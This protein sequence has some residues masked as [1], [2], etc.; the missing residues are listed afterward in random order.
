MM[1]KRNQFSIGYISLIILIGII[2]GAVCIPLVSADPEQKTNSTLRTITDMTGR[3]VSVPAEIQKVA[4]FVGP[5]Y[6]K[7]FLLGESDKIAMVSMN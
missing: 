3:V 1:S 5:S 7:M 6:E 4:C 2:A